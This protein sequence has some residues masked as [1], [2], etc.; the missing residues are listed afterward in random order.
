MKTIN[1]P[2]Q[3][4]LFDPFEGVIGQ[5]GWKHIENGW[6]SLFREVLRCPSSESPPA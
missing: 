1:D 5:T 6:Q 3:Q 4:R 2:A